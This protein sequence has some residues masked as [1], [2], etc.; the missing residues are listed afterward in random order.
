MEAPHTAYIVGGSLRD[1]L[2]D[3]DIEEGD[4]DIATSAKPDEVIQLFKKTIPTGLKHGTVTV[5]E[6]DIPVEITTYRS[7]EAYS[8]SRRPDGVRFLNSIEDDLSRRDFTINA[9]AYNPFTQDFIDLFEGAKDLF[10]GIIRCVGNPDER[11]KEDGL[12]VLRA[13]RFAT[14]LEFDI[15]DN[16]YKSI[17]NNIESFKKIAMER[18]KDELDKMMISKKPSIGFE[19]LLDTSL[20]SVIMPEFLESVDCEQNIYHAYDVW[21]HSL[22]SMDSAPREKPVVRWSALFHDIG[23]PFAKD[24][25]TNGSVTFYNHENISENLAK[26]IMKR[27]RFSKKEIRDISILVKN[28]MFN[29]TPEWSD[30]A[31]RRLIRRVGRKRIGDLF[32]LRL[33]DWIGNGYTAGFPQYLDELK[34]RIDEILKANDALSV[35]DLEINGNDVMQV[36]KIEPCQKIG[37]ILNEILNMVIEKPEL[38][39]R[40]QL[41]EILK[42]IKENE[43]PS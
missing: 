43:E 6:N 18:V 38:N 14:V 7:E 15:E 31:V 34:K 33:A 42:D 39:T 26:K 1:I 28:H 36:F 3:K 32:D 17:G 10:S 27:L 24:T 41:L 40:E 30:S 35:N 11:F 25:T 2:L 29:Y 20:L 19:M 8:D 13:I 5:I 22:V 12:R 9:M 16:T 4:W 37:E 23:K 21:G